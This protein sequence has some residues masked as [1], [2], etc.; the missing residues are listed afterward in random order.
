MTCLTR[1]SSP[2]SCLDNLYCI[3]DDDASGFTAEDVGVLGLNMISQVDAVLVMAN[4][5]S[6]S[7]SI[8]SS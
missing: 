4:F 3:S 7:H 8:L 1:G 5:H 2:C 6:S